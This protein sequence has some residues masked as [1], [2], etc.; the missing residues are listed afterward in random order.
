MHNWIISKNVWQSLKH[1][2]IGTWAIIDSNQWRYLFIFMNKTHIN[3]VFFSFLHLNWNSDTR[4]VPAGYHFHTKNSI[5]WMSRRGKKKRF[6]M[7]NSWS[8]R[9]KHWTKWLMCLLQCHQLTFSH[10]DETKKSIFRLSQSISVSC[11]L[12][13]RHFYFPFSI[14]IFVFTFNLRQVQCI[15]L[16]AMNRYV[17]NCE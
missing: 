13:D 5:L 3:D 1:W 12:L 8:R 9:H 11:L 10:N 4:Q 7:E 2:N 14:F 15:A 6:F 16:A 17:G